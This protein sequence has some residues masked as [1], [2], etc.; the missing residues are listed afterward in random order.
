M[1]ERRTRFRGW[2]TLATKTM[3]RGG[4][5]Y[6][7]PTGF[8]FIVKFGKLLVFFNI[9]WMVELPCVSNWVCFLSAVLAEVWGCGFVSIFPLFVSWTIY[10]LSLSPC[11]SS[12]DFG[13]E[14]WMLIL[15][16]KRGTEKTITFSYHVRLHISSLGYL[17][18]SMNLL[19]N[20]NLTYPESQNPRIP[21]WIA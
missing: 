8:T 15:K 10:R 7:S 1:K 18:H 20:L 3:V 12:L 17:A 16:K 5:S 19:A 11:W 4:A 9:L 14:C 6:D 13:G 2:R 21:V